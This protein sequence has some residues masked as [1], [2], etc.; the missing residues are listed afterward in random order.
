MSLPTCRS[1][2]SPDKVKNLVS[3]IVEKRFFDSPE[4]RFLFVSVAQGKEELELHTI[5][6]DD[7][8]GK[9]SRT[10]GIGEYAGKV[11]TIPPEFSA[12]EQELK[13]LKDSAFPPSEK[14]CHLAR[15]VNFWN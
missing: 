7:G 13:Q 5:A 12:I 11:E 8:I 4:K 14:T 15:A 2:V 1:R 6:I 3:L 9:A 10:F